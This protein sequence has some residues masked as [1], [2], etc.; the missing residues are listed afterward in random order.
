VHLGDLRDSR[1]AWSKDEFN[2]AV[3]EARKA[4]VL[5]LTPAEG[6]HGVTD[7]DKSSAIVEK[8]IREGEETMMLYASVRNALRT[9]GAL[10]NVFC[11][12]GPGGGKDPSCSPGGSVK[13]NLT[14]AP[15]CPSV[16]SPDAKNAR[17]GVPADSVPPPPK[18]GI[19]RLPNLTPKQRAV[20]TRYAEA[21]L[22][23][24]DKM[25]DKYL[26]ALDRRKVGEHPNVFATDDVKMLNKDWN[27]DKVRLGEK[28][29]KDSRDSM[30]RYNSAVHQTAN[31]IAKRAFLKYLDETVSSY[32]EGDP[33]RSVFVTNGGCAAGKGSTVSRAEK[34]GDPHFGM[35]PAA[36]K[37]GAIWDAAGE[38]NSTENEWVKRECDKRGL[39][40][41]FAYVWAD[42]KDTWSG[43]SR[44]VIRRAERKGR[45]VDA[46]LFADSYA[47][48]AKNMH[49]FA[50]K[51]KSDGTQFIFVDNR[52]KGAPKLLS[53]FP[54]ETLAW[55]SEKIY[56]TAVDDLGRRR[57]SLSKSLVKGGL[58]GT[59]I[60]GPPKD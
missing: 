19:P 57:G 2:H 4:R 49:A 27:P 17:V 55:D 38:Q 25:V 35:T 37:V 43:E 8:G 15:C 60:W 32:P 9:V 28:L 5:T 52:D 53:E 45:M 40:S 11:P 23:N 26:S 10:V 34:A 22:A 16:A 20:E 48:G 33:R 56:K 47:E 7:R 1:P 36:G 14:P 54:K 3:K 30:A 59:V 29:T 24:P 42:P 44:G 6:R 13:G 46:R 21:Y 18:D 58:N 51:H 41:V 12:T 50:E 31:A 39:K